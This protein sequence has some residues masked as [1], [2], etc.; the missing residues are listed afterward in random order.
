MSS[1]DTPDSTACRCHASP[2]A[3]AL[4]FLDIMEEGLTIAEERSMNCF[5]PADDP[6]I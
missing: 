4:L 1:C 5:D 2:R 6:D 3:I